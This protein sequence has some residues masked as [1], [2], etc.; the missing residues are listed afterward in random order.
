MKMIKNCKVLFLV[1]YSN[2]RFFRSNRLHTV[3]R[4]PAKVLTPNGYIED[5]TS[6]HHEVAPNDA[7]LDLED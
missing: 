7:R 5:P 1:L 2:K 4:E 3:A 6:L